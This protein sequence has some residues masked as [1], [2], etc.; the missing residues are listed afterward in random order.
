[1]LASLPLAS[2]RWR[3]C[4]VCRLKGKEWWD[5]QGVSQIVVI[6]ISTLKL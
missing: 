4:P 5:L 6:L 3:F 2:L 1:M